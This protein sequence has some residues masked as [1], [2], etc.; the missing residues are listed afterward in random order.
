[1]SSLPPGTPFP[2]PPPP[3]PP[4]SGPGGSLPWEMRQ[5]I[6][7]VDALV[8]TVKLIITAPQ[9]AFQ[10]MRPKANDYFEP[11]LFA[12]IVSWVGVIASQIYGLVF[13]TA[14]LGMFQ[15]YL[16]ADVQRQLGPMLAR[17]MV[18]NVVG[19]VLGPIFIAIFLFI[20]AGIIHLCLMIVGGTAQSAAGFEGTFRTM[21]YASVAD[22]ANLVPFVGGLIAFVWKLVLVVIGLATLH[23]TSSGRAVAAVLIPIAL[24]CVCLVVFIGAIAALVAGGL[25]H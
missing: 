23:R 22:L 14:T 3:P 18:G 9:D 13:G 6:G 12:V 16:P 5:S 11:L 25:R 17:N 20:G 8:E 10:R 15:K 2:P 1:M 4:S 7:F 19:M 21:A 24:C